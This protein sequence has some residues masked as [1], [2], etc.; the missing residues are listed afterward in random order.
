ML[1]ILLQGLGGFETELLNWLQQSLP[2]YIPPQI[3][4]EVSEVN[5]PLSSSYYNTK[6]LQF[7]AYGILSSL[8]TM[9]KNTGFFRVLALTNEDIYV[10]G[11][12]FV[13]GLAQKPLNPFDETSLTALVSTNR[14]TTGLADLKSRVFKTRLLKEAV[15]E[16]G[17]TLTLD[18]CV[19]KCVMRFSNTIIE[20]DLKPA[21]FCI[22]CLNKIRVYIENMMKIFHR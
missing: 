10:E 20:T 12:N 19:K 1:K 13:F 9:F 15:H 4:F 3:I 7:N 6:R 17:H 22:E 18:H 21:S 14:L 2:S 5:L 11:L 16:L 8:S